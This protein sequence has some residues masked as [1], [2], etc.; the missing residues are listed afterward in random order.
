[1]LADLLGLSDTAAIGWHAAAG[2]DRAAYVARKL[3]AGVRP[4]GP[5]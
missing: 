2:G 4:P 1:M 3:H 5:E